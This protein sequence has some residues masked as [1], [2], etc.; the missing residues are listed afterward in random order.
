MR[1]LTF[2]PDRRKRHHYF[3]RNIY[4]GGEGDILD[5]KVFEDY[6]LIGASSGST[7]MRVI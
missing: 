6:L 3:S 1:Q 5:L 2:S 4:G 7:L